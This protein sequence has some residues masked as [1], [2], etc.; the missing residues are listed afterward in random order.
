[1][2]EPA[3]PG[4][5]V[6][7]GGTRF[8]L[9]QH[10]LTAL[11]VVMGAL[12]FLLG[13]Q[14]MSLV[15]IE[16]SG[17]NS[18]EGDVVK[19][20]VLA[21]LYAASGLLLIKRT[22][23]SKSLPA[24]G[25]P[26][27]V[28]LALCMLSVT[29]A[30]LPSVVFRRSVALAGTFAVGLYAGMCLDER[31]IVQVLIRSTWVLLLA[32]FVIAAVWPEAGLD[33][34]G[35]LRGVTAHKN[36]L[37]VMAAMGLLALAASLADPQREQGAVSRLGFLALCV[38]S[39]VLSDSATPVPVLGFALLVLVIA[40]AASPRSAVPSLLLLAATAVAIL[41]P[42]FAAELGAI[43]A[44]FGRNDD[45]SGRTF[46]WAYSIELLQHHLVL[47]WGFGGFWNGEAALVFLRWAHFP[48]THAHNGFLQLGLD[49][50]VAGLV[51]FV[52]AL[53][54]FASRARELLKTDL[55]YGHWFVFA[56]AAFYLAGNVT[57]SR[58]L[59]GNQALTMLFV[60]VV[61]RTNIRFKECSTSTATDTAAPLA[62]TKLE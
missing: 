55:A 35:R 28:L 15:S 54:S 26:L 3:V 43:A 31:Q 38:A 2:L 32:S 18:T 12:P 41:V 57:E 45:F 40:R 20:L 44:L 56:Y 53:L 1:M 59:A 4:P 37:G 17:V 8:T 16:E 50:G 19:Q 33:P 6:P 21:C 11:I 39:L 60:F 13:D 23:L 30:E 47:G 36:A 48:V 51:L 62:A 49:A 14:P 9:D 24:I 10:F 22:R 58:L 27:L 7:R 42:F 34:E 5:A 52:A 61:V 25:A 46:V 29:W